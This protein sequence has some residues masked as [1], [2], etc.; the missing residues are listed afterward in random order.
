MDYIYLVGALYDDFSDVGFS[1]ER[2]ETDE[3]KALYYFNEYIKEYKKTEWVILKMK[4]SSK[5]YDI[6]EHIHKQ[7]VPHFNIISDGRFYEDDYEG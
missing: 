4:V 2:V 5:V 1:F 7:Y 6:R 3:Q